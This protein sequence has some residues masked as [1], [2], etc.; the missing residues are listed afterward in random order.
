MGL[1]GQE[2]CDHPKGYFHPGPA[3]G[4]LRTKG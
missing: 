2:L 4:Q 1:K 3:P